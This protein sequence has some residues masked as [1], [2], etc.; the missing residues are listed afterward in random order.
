MYVHQLSS[1]P[2]LVKSKC[3]CVVAFFCSYCA[4]SIF[5]ISISIFFISN[6][7]N[8][9][10]RAYMT[11]TSIFSR[12]DFDVEKF[13]RNYMPMS[14]MKK[15]IKIAVTMKKIRGGIERTYKNELA[16]EFLYWCD[17]F[18][19][20]A[21]YSCCVESVFLAIVVVA[22]DEKGQKDKYRMF[23][24]YFVIGVTDVADVECERV[25]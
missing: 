8:G 12:C 16:H 7:V 4:F 3:K 22:D 20:V 14:F 10:L 1:V 19:F 17:D 11:L 21:S 25:K 15:I 6:L 2:Y 18:F 23:C 9:I 5:F 13:F 24:C